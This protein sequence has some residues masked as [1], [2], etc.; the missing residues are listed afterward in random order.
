MQLR[1]L[2]F[3]M[4]AGT[5]T[6][7][8]VPTLPA[9]ASSHMDAPLITLDDAANTPFCCGSVRSTGLRGVASWCQP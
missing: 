6:T 2:V 9:L 3:G 4:L 1:N 7:A 8:V 5:A